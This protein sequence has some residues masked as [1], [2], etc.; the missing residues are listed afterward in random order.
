LLGLVMADRVLL[1]A[2]GDVPPPGGV[3][4]RPLTEEDHLR[5]LR[6]C[7]PSLSPTAHAVVVL[8]VSGAAALV[9]W[10]AFAVLGSGVPA[11]HRPRLSCVLVALSFLA[12]WVS[13]PLSWFSRSGRGPRFSGPGLKWVAGFALWGLCIYALKVFTLPEGAAVVGFLDC[14]WLPAVTTG[15]LVPWAVELWRGANLLYPTSL[16][17][18]IQRLTIVACG[19]ALAIGA[20]GLHVLLVNNETALRSLF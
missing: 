17:V 7:L 6:R 4:S 3:G 18:A 2:V 5:Q 10:G 11:E 16:R 12:V 19:I 20:A 9:Y 13:L 14:Y 15:L 1:N 8:T